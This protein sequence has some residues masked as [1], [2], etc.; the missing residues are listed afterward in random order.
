MYS[1][2]LYVKLDNDSQPHFGAQRNGLFFGV[3]PWKC[4]Y[5]RS[6]KMMVFV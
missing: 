3:G 4:S 2:I 6:W 1:D 5:N